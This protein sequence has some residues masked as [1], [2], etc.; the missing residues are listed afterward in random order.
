MNYMPK[1]CCTPSGQANSSVTLQ[2]I[3]DIDYFVLTRSDR[4]V[5]YLTKRRIQH[6]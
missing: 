2:P 4:R 1:T 3:G 5:I 6:W